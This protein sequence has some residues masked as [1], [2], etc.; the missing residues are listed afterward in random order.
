V[1]KPVPT[2]FAVGSLVVHRK[3]PGLGVG[4]VFCR[5]DDIVAV[6]FI[7]TAGVRKLSRLKASFLLPATLAPHG[8]LAGWNVAFDSACRAVTTGKGTKKVQPPFVAAWTQEHALERFTSHYPQAFR[9]PR[10]APA[11]REWKWEQHQ[12][13]HQTFPGGSFRALALDDPDTAAKVVLKLVQTKAAPLLSPRGELPA[14][15]DALESRQTQSFLIA[16]ADAIEA[17]VPERRTFEHLVETLTSLPTGG[18]VTRLATWPILTA[19]PFLI[20][21]DAYM[22][23]KPRATKMVSRNLGVDLLYSPALKWDTYDRVLEWSRDLLAFLRP[24]GAID[25]IDVQSFIWTVADELAHA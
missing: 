9:D 19:A 12:L 8:D 16:L 5:T 1:P 14:L 13:W 17:Q 24:H 2:S 21:P 11:E 18:A 7:D 20:R 6:G 3:L 10:Y 25:M 4:K 22:F 15:W 23:V